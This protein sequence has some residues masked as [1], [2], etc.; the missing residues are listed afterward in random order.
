MNEEARA[1]EFA[2]S[3]ILFFNWYYVLWA[4]NTWAIFLLCSVS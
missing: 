2:Y 1:L 3:C 4:Q